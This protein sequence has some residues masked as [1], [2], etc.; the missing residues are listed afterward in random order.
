MKRLRG[1]WEYVKGN[2]G[3]WVYWNAS[4]KEVLDID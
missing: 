2:M 4:R 3:S 1:A